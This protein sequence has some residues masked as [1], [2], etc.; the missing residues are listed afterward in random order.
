MF[1]GSL[2]SFPKASF[3]ETPLSFSEK[4]QNYHDPGI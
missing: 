4:E 2:I 1:E 3:S